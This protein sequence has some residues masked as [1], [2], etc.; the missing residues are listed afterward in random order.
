MRLKREKEERIRKEEEEKRRQEEE[1]QKAAIL[2]EQRRRRE[3]EIR[4]M[5]KEKIEKIEKE[6]REKEELER[7][8]QQKIEER[9][10]QLR[11][12]FE[13]SRLNV[14][15]NILKAP[16]HIIN[17]VKQIGQLV[18]D[19]ELVKSNK[20][21]IEIT[22][23]DPNEKQDNT[24]KETVC[25]ISKES[26]VIVPRPS[27][28]IPVIPSPEQFAIICDQIINT[29]NKS[30]KET[31]RKYVQTDEDALYLERINNMILEQIT[32]ETKSKPKN[33]NKSR[34]EI[35]SYFRRN[36]RSRNKSL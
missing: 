15:S 32:I 10:N 3:E 4:R 20:I 18:C 31:L 16:E 34:E 25:T 28:V 7:Q 2:E 5:E 36:K 22:Y 26:D 33:E 29:P 11:D 21:M 35:L 1:K 17:E 24:D 8:R 14:N 30:S 19:N 6:K 12:E 9:R 13:K 23:N 27:K